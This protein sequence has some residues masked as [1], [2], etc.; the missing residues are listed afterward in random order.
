METHKQDLIETSAKD[1]M[2]VVP[3]NFLCI[4]STTDK[5]KHTMG[6]KQ[7]IPL[8]SGL[9]DSTQR[10][11]RLKTLGC[12]QHKLLTHP[13]VMQMITIKIGARL[14]FTGFNPDVLTTARDSHS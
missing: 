9:I 4:S 3:F 11:I 7:N 12:R 14:D 2:S 10:N 5:A 13:V 6:T 1:N 8:N